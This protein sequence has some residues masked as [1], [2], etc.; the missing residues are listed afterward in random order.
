MKKV[1]ATL[2][3]LCL[4]IT[5]A[6]CQG[7]PGMLG[8]PPD[9]T[10]SFTGNNLVANNAA[11][12][13]GQVFAPSSL[14]ANNS[15]ALVGNNS[16]ALV[17]NNAAAYRTASLQELPV[18]KAEVEAV[19]DGQVV[20]K[21]TTDETGRYS[22]SNL[23]KEKAYLLRVSFTLDGQTYQEL[24]IGRPLA[25][26][27]GNTVNSASTLVTAK[28]VTQGTPLDQVNLP[29]Y[30][31]TVN[32]VAAA[33]SSID[34]SALTS[35]QQSS[36]A[37][38]Q[39]SQSNQQVS[40]SFTEATTAQSTTDPTPTPTPPGTQATYD[41]KEYF[42]PPSSTA[43]ATFLTTTTTESPEGTTVATTS[44][45]VRIAPSTYTSSSATL[46]KTFE[47]GTTFDSTVQ[48][49]GGVVKI[50]TMSL[51]AP[52]FSSE[53]SDVT[54]FGASETVHYVLQADNQSITVKA[55]T[56]TCVKLLETTKTNQTVTNLRSLWYAKGV[57]IGPVKARIVSTEG[58][59]TTTQETVMTSFQP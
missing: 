58:S 51:G 48:I 47:S 40:T 27:T 21:A 10:S 15:A 37:F 32:L 9:N 12:L 42:F 56:Y 3:V 11:S 35:T 20:S 54:P 26:Q 8:S 7:I 53:G 45:T 30:Y 29:R 34:R 23:A 36:S 55:G 49:V 43:Q 39:V 5:V 41:P 18:I 6:G 31:D 17:S 1:R 22:L 13:S 24:A 50:D 38:D 19:R 25:Q 44:F 2:G 28:V 16:A 52:V 14:V 59:T 4:G 57:G 33:Q 46:R